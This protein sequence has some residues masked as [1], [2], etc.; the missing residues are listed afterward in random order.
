MINTDYIFLTILIILSGFFSGSE[1]SFFSLSNLALEKLKKKHPK[2]GNLVGKLLKDPQKLL[3]TILICNMFANILAT[4]IALRIFPRLIA[5]ALMTGLILIF[6]EVTPKTIAIRVAPGIAIKVA[7]IFYILSKVLA[8]FIFFF[9]K[10]SKGLV[11]ISSALFY[12]NVKEP[13]FY[14]SEEMIEVVNESQLKGV[15]NKEE[16]NILGNL[17][18]F[19]SADI[20]KVARPRNE[21]F[22]ISIETNMGKIL[23]IIKEKKYS[24]I[25]VWEKKEENIIGILHIKDLLGIKGTKR[26]LSY[27]RNILRKPLFIPDSVKAEQLL[28]NF[29]TTQNH[30]AIVIDEFGGISGIATL[31]DILEEIIGEVVDKEDVKPLYH[32]YNQSMIEIEAKIEIDEFNKVFKTNLKAK[33]AISVGGY[34]LEKTKRIPVVGEIIKIDQLQFKISGAQLNKLEKIM[35]TKIKKRSKSKEGNV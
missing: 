7:P 3:V 11:F 4:L 27:Y 21:M 23:E 12:N 25:P 28:K 10:I 31:E 16:G 18:K 29:Q 30:I 5:L 17:L 22:T 13:V 14:Q 19:P 1:T 2:R 20:T 6:G 24:R 32:K 34:L 35:V 26:K 9:R 33:D 15:L 8:P